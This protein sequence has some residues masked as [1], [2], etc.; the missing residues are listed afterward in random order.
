MPS[1]PIIPD[2]PLLALITKHE[3]SVASPYLDSRGF[4]TV[5]VGHNLIAHPL[6]GESYP[7]SPERIQ[8]VL[9]DDLN[10]VVIAL[11][12]AL[13]WLQEIDEVRQAV[14]IDM[15]FNLG[16]QGL[17]KWPNTLKA[18]QNGDW[19]TASDGMLGSLWAKQVGIRAQEDATMMLTGAWPDGLC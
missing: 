5:G 13:P 10:Q 3:G 12:A 7:M 17:L 9:A 1:E 14:L 16:V 19:Q 8:A 6:P 2:P 15:G 11:G 4:Q 18:I